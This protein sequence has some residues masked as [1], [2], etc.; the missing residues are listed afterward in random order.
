MAGLFNRVFGGQS[1]VSA[2]NVDSDADFADFAANP[3]P[4]SHAAPSAVVATSTS[5]AAAAA[6]VSPGPDAAVYTKWYRVWERTTPADFYQEMAIVPF[7]LLI[8]LTYLWG[9]RANRGRAKQW[10]ETHRPIME[11]EFAQV[12]LG[13]GKA[14][15]KQKTLSEFTTYATGRQSV[16]WLDVKL[17]LYPRY[18]PSRWFGQWLISFFMESLPAPTERMEAVAVCFDGKE[19]TLLPL[20]PMAS[21]DSAF[22]G[23]V[24]A[25]VHKDVMAKLRDER[26]DVSLTTTKEHPKLP[27]WTTVMSESAEVT[28]ALLTP[29]LIQAIT[30]TGDDFE[31]LIVSDM[32]VDAPKTVDDLT[33]Q[34]RVS[35]LTKLNASSSASS[36]F[37]YFL[38]MPDQL[39]STAHFRPEAL[40]KVRATRQ[41]ELQRIRKAGESEKDVDRRSEAEKRK[42][43][44]RDRKLKKMSAEE[45][46]KFLEQE[47]KKEQRKDMARRSMRA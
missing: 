33:P 40:R 20:P 11:A 4:P 22:D 28:Q 2:G 21:K 39:V 8:I 15:L 23:F 13:K 19:K 1:S 36:L 38:R 42:K 25:I 27:V 14:D 24:W 37:S 9:S 32:P 45:Q 5:A 43:E 6:A 3:A 34:K 18:N 29:E 31:A 10:M 41:E 35:L 44:E 26:Y 17:Q 47:K 30:D 12:G 7:L 46:R 16:A